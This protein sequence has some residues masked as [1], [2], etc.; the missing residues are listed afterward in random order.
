VIA[1]STKGLDEEGFADWLRLN[2]SKSPG[3]KR[4]AIRLK[5]PR[6]R[7]VKRKRK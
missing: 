1:L 7:V 2:S 5:K 3:P 6:K 4:V